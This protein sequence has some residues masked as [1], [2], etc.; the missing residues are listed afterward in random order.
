[1]YPNACHVSN[2]PVNWYE[3]GQDRTPVNHTPHHVIQNR[4]GVN[5]T[6]HQYGVVPFEFSINIP[7]HAW[8]VKASR[9]ISGRFEKVH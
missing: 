6:R 7:E 5:T 3:H 8:Q 9:G 2:I 1:L 4:Y